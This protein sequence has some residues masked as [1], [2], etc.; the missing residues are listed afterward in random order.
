MPFS[1]NVNPVETHFRYEVGL[2]YS[3]INDEDFEPNYDF[4]DFLTDDELDDVCGDDKFCRYDYKKTTNPDMGEAA[5][6]A[7]TEWERTRNWTTNGMP[8]KCWF[9]KETRFRD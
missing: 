5:G 8:I 9:K 4:P 3:L 2:N 1:G 7:H 6:H